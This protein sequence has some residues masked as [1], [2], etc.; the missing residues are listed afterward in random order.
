MELMKK[1][2]ISMA[3]AWLIMGMVFFCSCSGSDYINAIPANS[4]AV[5]SIDMQ[6]MAENNPQVSRTGVLKSLLHVEDV[7]E[8]GIDVSEKL[9]LFETADGNL[10]LCAKVSDAADLEDWLNQLSKKQKICENVTEKKSFHFSVLKNSWL[11]GFSDQTLLVMGPVV[12]DAQAELQ[13]MMIKYLKADEEHGIKSSPMFERLD[14]ISSP[15][16]LVAQAQ[17]LPEKFV[18]PFTLGAPKNAD[19]SQI[20]IAAEMNVQKGMLRIKGETFSFNETIDKALQ[21]AVQN[22]RPIKGSYVKS[23]PDDALAGIFMNVNGE[24]FLPMMQS[25]RS[26]QTLLMGINQAVDMDNIMRSVDGDM[27]IVLPTLGDADLK[28]M[29]AA[30]LAHS[31]WL[32]DVDYWKTSCPAGAKIANW[33][34]NSYFYTDGKTSFY[35]GVTDDKQF[36]SGSDEL[37]AQYAVKPS[38]HPID[39]KIQKLIVGQKLA[40]VINL[41]KSS[42]GSGTGKD[43]AISTV[44]GLLAPVFG[45]L[46]SVVYTLK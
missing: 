19:A 12:A 26:L 31:K 6:K 45:N 3:L 37:T 18:A 8:C 15:M 5:I 38:N 42:D 39:A 20:V 36:F 21:K 14:S 40:M 25:N 44:T 10:G 4:S 1:M 13:R 41:A 46:T 32:G 23:M 24:Q 33:G 30:K 17:A 28:M 22:Y 2:N 7:A 27:A 29:M 34:K 35:F 9:Y 11:V 43:D 16:A